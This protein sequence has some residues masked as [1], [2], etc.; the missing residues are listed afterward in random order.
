MRFLQDRVKLDPGCRTGIR[1]MTGLEIEAAKSLLK[2][3]QRNGSVRRQERKD[4][5]NK[6]NNDV[7]VTH[8]SRMRELTE[9]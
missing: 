9:N 7:A 1:L 6:N 2:T 3:Q 5:N 4:S 8:D